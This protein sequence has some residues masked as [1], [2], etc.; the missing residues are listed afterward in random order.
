MKTILALDLGTKTGWAVRLDDGDVISGAQSFKTPRVDGAGMCFLR[1][2]RWL[3]AVFKQMKFSEVYFE[4]VRR[5]AGT[6]A[7]HAYGGYK[8]HLTAWCE[9]MMIPYQSVPVGTIKLFATGKGNASKEMMI[10]AAVRCGFSV[11]NDD[12]A[13]ALHLLRY[14]VDQLAIEE[15]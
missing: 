2:R 8:A 7:A 10:D 11:D 14:A 6:S 12:E 15:F 13:D 9:E 5:H 1:F 4:E 3:S